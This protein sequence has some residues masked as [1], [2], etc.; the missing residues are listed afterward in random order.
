MIESSLSIIS[1]IFSAIA[2]LLTFIG[3]DIKITQ[4]FT[5]RQD[6]LDRKKRIESAF[7][8]K[9]RKEWSY[10]MNKYPAKSE[11]GE[12]AVNEFFRFG[13]DAYVCTLPSEIIDEISSFTSK[14]I[15]NFATMI[16]SIIGV[17]FSYWLFHYE[18]PLISSDLKVSIVLSI[19]A[20]SLFVAYES[21]KNMKNIIPRT[22]KLRQT[23]FKVTELMEIEDLH[24]IFD[25]LN[26]SK[27]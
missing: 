26:L 27:S 12:D 20:I 6:V 9:L 3:L 18:F 1:F 23:F 16:I 2:L 4:E 25:D 24:N 17:A 5:E 11:L 22:V 15:S 14:M 13:I 19:F 21:L 10:L 8:E 7:R